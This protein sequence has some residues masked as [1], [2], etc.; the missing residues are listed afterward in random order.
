M[1]RQFKKLSQ[2]LSAE[3]WNVHDK[4]IIQNLH[5]DNHMIDSRKQPIYQFLDPLITGIS[6]GTSPHRISYLVSYHGIA[7]YYH[8]KLLTQSV[9]SP[10]MTNMSYAHNGI[11]L[12]LYFGM[13]LT[14]FYIINIVR[15]KRYIKGCA[16]HGFSQFLFR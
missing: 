4:Y 6:K 1:K 16:Y 11:S 13:E 7:P 12:H 5:M 9:Q 2:L 14:I 3:F 8:T 10:Q 15:T